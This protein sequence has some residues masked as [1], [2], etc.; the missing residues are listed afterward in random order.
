VP[1]RESVNAPLSGSGV[2]REGVCKCSE[3][4]DLGL[5]FRV[6]GGGE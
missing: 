1:R 5:G 6:S 2:E 3:R 4:V